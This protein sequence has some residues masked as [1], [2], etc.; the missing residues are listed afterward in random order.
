MEELVPAAQLG[1]TALL[2]GPGAAHQPLHISPTSTPPLQGG[3]ETPCLVGWASSVLA[4]ILPELLLPGSLGP[5]RCPMMSPGPQKEELLQR[6][7]S[8]SEVCSTGPGGTESPLG[9]S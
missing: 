9:P 1:F 4:A 7:L 5:G 3:T 2:W 6:A 8:E